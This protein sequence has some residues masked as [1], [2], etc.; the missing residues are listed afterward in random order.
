MNWHKDDQIS[1]TR[2]DGVNVVNIT[3]R[4]TICEKTGGFMIQLRSNYKTEYSLIPITWSNESDLRLNP[5]IFSSCCSFPHLPILL[6]PHIYLPPLLL[7][8]HSSLFMFYPISL[9]HCIESRNEQESDIRIPPFLKDRTEGYQ[10]LNVH[11]TC[12]TLDQIITSI[13]IITYNDHPNIIIKTL[14]KSGKRGAFVTV[15][16]TFFSLTYMTLENGWNTSNICYEV[17]WNI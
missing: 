8:H 15:H 11:P 5:A 14:R 16:Q 12:H 1:Q 2:C 6:F 13:I 7:H 3:D 10:T 17:S 9:F 4:Y